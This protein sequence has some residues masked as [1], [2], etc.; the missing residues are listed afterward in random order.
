MPAEWHMLSLLDVASHMHPLPQSVLWV[1][2][3]YMVSE[4]TSAVVKD[5]FHSVSQLGTFVYILRFQS[6]W[7]THSL[8]F[9]WPFGQVLSLTDWFIQGYCLD[10]ANVK[11]CYFLQQED[12][13][14]LMQTRQNWTGRWGQN[15]YRGVARIRSGGNRFST[16]KSSN[17][18]KLQE[19]DR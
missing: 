6:T 9:L 8:R 13:V 2:E 18:P 17:P 15:P 11:L 12:A 16:L 10:I 7:N 19:R 3:D 1:S 4:W 14:K 5:L